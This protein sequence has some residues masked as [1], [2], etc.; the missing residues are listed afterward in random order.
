MTNKSTAMHLEASFD[1]DQTSDQLMWHFV[2]FDQHGE[3]IHGQ[4]AGM[5]NFT[6]GEKFY[7]NVIAG[8]DKPIAGVKV[9]NCVLITKPFI[10]QC[11]PN[12]S[13]VYAPPSPF[14]ADKLGAIIGACVTLPADEFKPGPA[15]ESGK[16]YRKTQHWDGFLTV[17]GFQGRWD[18]SF[19]LTVQIA[20]PGGI[21]ELRVFSFDP[22]GE[23]ST[24]GIG[25]QEP[26]PAECNLEPEV[27]PSSGGV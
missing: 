6:V 2:R 19:V 5:I 10:Y 22:E 13:T 11:G 20:R 23:V 21:N 1:I 25:E 14:N 8:S 3:K 9:I 4:E 18:I 27:D 15:D 26:S 16:Y 24:G 17:G 7:I 12:Q